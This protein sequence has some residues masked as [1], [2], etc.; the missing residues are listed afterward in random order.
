MGILSRINQ[1]LKANINSL[2]ERAED[3]E[4]RVNQIIADMEEAI[5]VGKKELIEARAQ[6]KLI[7]E[8]C[9]ALEEKVKVWEERAKLALK[10]GD[11]ALAREALLMKHKVLRELREQKELFSAQKIE[12]EKLEASLEELEHKLNELKG[13]KNIIIN[14]MMEEKGRSPLSTNSLPFKEFSRFEHNIEEIDAQVE[15]ERAVRGKWSEEELEAKFE[16][17]ERRKK[18]EEELEKLKK[19][20]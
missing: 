16:E 9:V 4:K 8:R 2:L 1:V 13:S 5:R 19:D 18:A 15:V 14:R 20:K 11:E 6:Q 10:A 7:Q 12:E 17:L 3:P